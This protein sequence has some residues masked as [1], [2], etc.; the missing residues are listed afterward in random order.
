VFQQASADMVDYHISVVFR[1]LNF[2]NYIRIQVIKLEK[3]PRLL[4]EWRPAVKISLII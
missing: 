3:K 2:K 1:A 4:F